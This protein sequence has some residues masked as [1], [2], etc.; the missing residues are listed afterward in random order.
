MYKKSD[1]RDLSNIIKWDLMKLKNQKIFLAMRL[2]W[3]IVQITVFAR[4]ISLIVRGFTGFDYFEFYLLGIYSSLLYTSSISRG[5]VLADEF[6]SGIVE[7]HL[8]LPVKRSVL[9]IGRILGSAISALLFTLPMMFVILIVL[10]LI[11]MVLEI[12]V[13]IIT[14][15]LFSIGVVSFV[16]LVVLRFKSGDATDIF[17]GTIDALLIRLSSVFYPLPIIAR[18]APYYYV[19]LV[20]P[21]THFS[22]FIRIIFIPEYVLYTLNPI[23]M[24]MY[25]LAL[26]IGLLVLL[27]DYY[28]KKL[29]AG[30]WK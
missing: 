2:S 5:Y 10:K 4:V 3:F 27:I 22:D 16:V 13:S 25:I 19:A 23:G 26:A 21:I 8:S 6:D 7:Y 18:I 14:A 28:E 20:N 15:F 29:E 24:V 12:I 9:V 11:T 30:S 17:F 1:L